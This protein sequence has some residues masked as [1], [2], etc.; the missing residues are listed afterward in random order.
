MT[1]TFINQFEKVYV[2][3]IFN[4]QK[5][6]F[7]LFKDKHMITEQLINNYYWNINENVC[8]IQILYYLWLNGKWYYNSYIKFLPH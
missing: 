5:V 2:Q 8:K 3:E 4:R 1:E 7:N 6:F